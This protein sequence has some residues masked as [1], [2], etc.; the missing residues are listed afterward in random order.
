MCFINNHPSRPPGLFKMM[1]LIFSTLIVVDSFFPSRAFVLPFSKVGAGKVAFFKSGKCGDGKDG[2]YGVLT[3]LNDTEPDKIFIEIM[4][5]AVC[6]NEKS[7]TDKV[8]QNYFSIDN[9]LSKSLELNDFT[10]GV[11]KSGFPLNVKDLPA[12]GINPGYFPYTQDHPFARRKGVYMVMCTADVMVGRHTV[13]YNEKFTGYHHGAINF[14]NLLTS[15]QKQFPNLKEIAMLGGSGAGVATAAWSGEVASRFPKAKVAAFVDS[16]F[17]LFPGTDAFKWFWDNVAWSPGKGGEKNIVDKSPGLPNF[18]WRSQLAIVEQLRKYPGRLKIAYVACN[19]DSVV[20]GDRSILS[21]YSDYNG[22][23]EIN[24]YQQMWSYISNLHK[25]APPGSAY[26]YIANCDSHHLTRNGFKPAHNNP[27][28][29]KIENFT[30]NFLLMKQVDPTDAKRT[31][32]WY[33]GHN[34]LAE[35]GACSE[36]KTREASLAMSTPFAPFRWSFFVAIG[37]FLSYL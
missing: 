13:K 15:L 9:F 1:S 29:M 3:P 11:L 19:N 28:M 26:S 22:S 27:G 24:Q 14:N 18:D 21:Q 5:G 34:V 6:F 7:C 33:E 8:L 12:Q 2:Y 16:G 23:K 31:S 4:G 32:F 35:G 37:F 20:F 25:C 17:H 36:A 30:N 10:I